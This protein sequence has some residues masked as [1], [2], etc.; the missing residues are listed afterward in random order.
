MLADFNSDT[1]IHV[2]NG[3]EKRGLIKIVWASKQLEQ[4]LPGGRVA[5]IFDGNKLAW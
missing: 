5:W 4:K 2:G 3:M 1:K